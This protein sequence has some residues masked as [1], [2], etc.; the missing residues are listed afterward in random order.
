M[1]FSVT[2]STTFESSEMR[3]SP[4]TINFPIT[5]FGSITAFVQTIS[6][7]SQFCKSTSTASRFFIY[8]FKFKFKC[9]TNTPR[10]WLNL[11]FWITENLGKEIIAVKFVAMKNFDSVAVNS[12]DWSAAWFHD[13]FIC[14]KF[15][16]IGTA[17]DAEI[18]SNIDKIYVHTAGNRN[19]F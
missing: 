7:T 3:Y 13:N 14:F 11:R 1:R 18:F 9:N 4:S 5:Q 8:V 15:F 17:G 19:I 16:W 10:I 6:S 2:T 12:I